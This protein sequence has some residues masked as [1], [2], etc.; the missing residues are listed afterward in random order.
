MAAEPETEI[1]NDATQI[2]KKPKRANSIRNYPASSFSDALDLGDA[3]YRFGSGQKIR[4][5]TLLEK[6]V[7]SPTSSVTRQMI[8]NSSRYG[9]TKGSYN[10]EYV[11]LTPDGLI[12]FDENAASQE[13]LRTRF[14][15]AIT[16]ISPFKKLYSEYVQKRIP[17]PEVMR[18][19]LKDSK[20]VMD[21]YAECI[22]TFIVNAKELGLLRTIGGSETL[23]S[24]EQAVEELSVKTIEQSPI[25]QPKQI[26]LTES[27]PIDTNEQGEEYWDKICFY[28]TTIGDEDS[29]Q[30]K[31][32]DLFLSSLIE[33][34]ITDL[35]MK[36]VRADKIGQ[37]GMISS[38][39]IEHVKKSRLVVVDLSF[40]NPNV[41]YEMA[42]R[43]SCKAPIV[44]II[45]KIDK[46]PFDVNQLRIIVV[47]NTDIY[48]LIPKLQTYRSEISTQARKALEDPEH[49]GNP[50]SIFFPSFWEKS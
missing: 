16:Q 9:I 12:I 6:M 44:H 19:F 17:A 43:H 29:E 42:L 5:L 37:T 28:I 31:H 30:R 2:E 20:E 21:D 34:A 23:I 24:I 49:G 10:A 40:L 26:I 18:D 39:I 33:P 35:G 22:D 38:Q 4:R 3:I 7:R 48:S 32:S 14:S 36:V 1:K 13:K 50:I 25:K 11:E 47:D 27:S 15:L 45:R 41:F 8:T 46:I